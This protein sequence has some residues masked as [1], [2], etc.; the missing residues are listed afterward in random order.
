LRGSHLFFAPQGAVEHVVAD[1]SLV[2]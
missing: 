2:V 1:V